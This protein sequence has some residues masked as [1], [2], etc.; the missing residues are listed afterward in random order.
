MEDAQTVPVVL[1]KIWLILVDGVPNKAG[2]KLVAN[3]LFLTK[4]EE[5]PTL[6]FITPMVATMSD[7]GKS[8][9]LTGV[10]AIADM[11]HVILVPTSHVPKRFTNGDKIPGSYGAPILLVDVDHR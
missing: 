1:L 10:N 8:T 2:I 11:L 6:C 9:K 5:M 3:V 7:F 4:V